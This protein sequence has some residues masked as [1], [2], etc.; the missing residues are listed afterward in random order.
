MDN[1]TKVPAKTLKKIKKNIPVPA[2]AT[3]TTS[4]TVLATE[5]IW[6]KIKAFFKRSESIFLARMAVVF[7]FAT[8]VMGAMDLSP[9]WA[10]FSTGT[11]F[12]SKQLMYLGVSVVGTGVM[13]E[14]A[15]RRNTTT[16]A[17]GSIS[18][19]TDA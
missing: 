15:R 5:S 19:K 11:D 12:T 18:S 17:D 9:V 1:L 7:G 3:P 2:V 6:D 14:L 8:S 4:L 13:F 16:E 10:L